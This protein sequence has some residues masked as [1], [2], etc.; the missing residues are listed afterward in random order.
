MGT[1]LC[2]QVG[3]SIFELF[4]RVLNSY[5]FTMEMLLVFLFLALLCVFKHGFKV[6][7]C[8]ACLLGKY[9]LFIF[10]VPLLQL[11]YVVKIWCV[12]V[13]ILG[14]LTM[15][16]PS[17]RLIVTNSWVLVLFS[18]SFPQW[19]V[20]RCFYVNVRDNS[21]QKIL[22]KPSHLMCHRGWVAKTWRTCWPA[23]L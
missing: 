14:C 20:T 13:A 11:G 23:W 10:H 22:W 21:T 9:L 16:S 3:V 1:E 5:K 12:A 17:I 8:Q 6:L 4:S 18:D 2:I 19:L 15:I 7:K